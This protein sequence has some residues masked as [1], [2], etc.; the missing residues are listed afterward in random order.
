MNAPVADMSLVSTF[1][2]LDLLDVIACSFTGS[3]AENLLC[4]RCS[5]ID[6]SFFV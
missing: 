2:T 3:L 1:R 5:F 6:N 4:R